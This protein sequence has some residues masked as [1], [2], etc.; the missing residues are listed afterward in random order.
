M[1]A[2]NSGRASR[3]RVAKFP[4]YLL[5]D[6]PAAH[7]QWLS[8]QAAEFD[9]S[10]ADVIRGLLC[11]RYK[12]K[13]PKESYRYNAEQD[14]QAA[15]MVLRLQPRLND[16]IDREAARRGWSKRRIILDTIEANYEKGEPQ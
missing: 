5:K 8:H 6:I 3:S 2:G 11:H 1:R 10:V 7:R 14:K 16:R 15:S 4:Q 9:V 12:L 13:C